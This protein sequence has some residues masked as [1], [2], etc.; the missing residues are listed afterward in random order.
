MDHV[1]EIAMLEDPDLGPSDANPTLAD[2]RTLAEG[3]LELSQ[4]ALAKAEADAQPPASPAGPPAA[5]TPPSSGAT[6][7]GGATRAT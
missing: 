1:V 6:P 7:A 2:L 3:F 5:E 4:S